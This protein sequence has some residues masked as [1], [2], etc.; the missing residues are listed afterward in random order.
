MNY[1]AEELTQ[2]PGFN[3]AHSIGGYRR[4]VDIPDPKNMTVKTRFWV[5]PRNPSRW[6]PHTGGA[7]ASPRSLHLGTTVETTAVSRQVLRA[8]AR[9]EAKR[10]ASL[11][12]RQPR[13]RAKG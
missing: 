1:T 6:V 11:A 12:K 5:R 10:Q 8:A 7:L 3:P 13:R 4:W 9:A 2:H